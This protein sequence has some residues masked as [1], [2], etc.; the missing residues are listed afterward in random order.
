MKN[1]NFICENENSNLYVIAVFVLSFIFFRLFLNLNNKQS[2]EDK[3]RVMNKSI[4][5]FEKY[6]QEN[7]DFFMGTSQ[8]N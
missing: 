7:E 5:Y 6:R 3:E 4:K 1:M 8:E 2:H